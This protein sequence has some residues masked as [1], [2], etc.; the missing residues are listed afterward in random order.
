ML[1]SEKIVAT[2]FF[3]VKL[4]AICTPLLLRSDGSDVSV[5]PSNYKGFFN[6]LQSQES[7]LFQ[8]GMLYLIPNGDTLN[9]QVS[10]KDVRTCQFKK[11]DLG[12]WWFYPGDQ[13][14][15]TMPQSDSFDFYTK[16]SLRGNNFGEGAWT[17][18][19]SNSETIFLNKNIDHL[20]SEAEFILDHAI[21]NLDSL[22]LKV[23]GTNFL[24]FSNISLHN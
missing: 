24:L 9:Y 10:L 6:K 22:T 3:H 16:L 12:Y 15:L 19:L 1:T 11:E 20:D 5:K 13:F 14:E 23:T 21:Y 17:L 18:E 2:G 8:N 4:G 7:H